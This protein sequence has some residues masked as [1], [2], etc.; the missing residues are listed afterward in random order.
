MAVRA[1]CSWRRPIWFPTDT[2]LLA[3]YGSFAELEAACETFCAGVSARVHRVTRRAPAEML[4]AERARLHPV[5]VGAHTVAFG[6]TRRV[7]ATSPMVTFQDGKYSVPARL[8]GATVWVRC[9]GVGSDERIVVV[10]VGD[11]GPVEVARHARHARAAP[12]SPMPD[13]RHFRAA[14]AGLGRVPKAKNP[15]EAAFLDLGLGARTWLM[16]AAA[17]GTTRMRIKMAD[18]VALAK[19]G[20]PAVVDWALGHAARSVSPVKM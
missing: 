2:N 20:D 12:G 10:H 13:D 4:A 19:L 6:T 14:P 17:A 15:D 7:E 8:L 11:T 16:E 3:E 5:P 1:R 9:H 18:A